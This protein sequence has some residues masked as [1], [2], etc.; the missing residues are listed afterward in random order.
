[1][2]GAVVALMIALAPAGETPA[3]GRTSYSGPHA[4]GGSEERSEAGARAAATRAFDAYSAGD[5]ETFR[6][7]WSMS[8]HGLITPPDYA[9]LQELCPPSDHGV[10]HTVESVRL[11]GDVAEVNVATT[12]GTVIHEFVFEDGRWRYRL[13]AEQYAEYAENSVERIVIDRRQADAC[14]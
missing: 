9:R 4:S 1:M 10:R 5:Y 12:D 13:S 6:E 7:M 2:I 14:A 11:A 8:A 3:G